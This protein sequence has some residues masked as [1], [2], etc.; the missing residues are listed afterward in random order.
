MHIATQLS[1][2]L[3][4][5]PGTLAEICRSLAKA[6][7]NIVAMTTSDAIDHAVDRL[8]VSE[9][10]KAVRLFEERG[11]LVIETQVLQ[12]AGPNHPG[13]LAQ[14]AQALGDAKINIE[15]LY[16]ATPQSSRNGVII[17]KCSDV[18]KAMKVLN[19][20]RKRR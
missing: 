9:P 12:S 2:F 13:G 10:K 4:N 7:I 19:K 3:E 6:K 16:F 14:I 1:I 15:Y 8:I 18:R 11:V 20:V 5:R 17:L